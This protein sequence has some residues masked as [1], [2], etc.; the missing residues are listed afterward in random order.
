MDAPIE[1]FHV[2]P[3]VVPMPFQTNDVRIFL[4]DGNETVTL[5]DAALRTDDA[6]DLLQQALTEMGRTVRDIGR[7]ILT[8]H[9]FDHTGLVGRLAEESGAELC[10][11]PDIPA[12]AALTYTYDEAHTAWMREVMAGFAVPE[13]LIERLVERRP[14]MKPIVYRVDALD[15]PL[16]DGELIDGFRVVHVPGHSPTDTLYVHEEKGFAITGDHILEHVTPNPILRRPPAGKPRAKSL[17]EF[18]ASL[19]RTHALDLGWC[20]PAHGKPYPDHR[21]V[22]DRILS[23][24]EKR[25]RRIMAWLPPSGASPY[26]TA[27]HLYPHMGVDLLF[28]CMSVAVGQLELL[29]SQGQLTSST[30]DGI[31]RYFPVAAHESQGTQ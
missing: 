21:P 30:E 18:D 7:I 31:V 27:L 3:V 6:W 20:F 8:H 23:T 15:R 13:D 19:R 25:N 9:H 14:V 2:H 28:F 12:A 16:A 4:Y 1:T 26:E 10:G 11:H 22:V 29:E 5:F 17:V 24:H